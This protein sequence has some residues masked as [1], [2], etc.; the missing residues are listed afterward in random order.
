MSIREQTL[1]EFV[2]AWNAGR[3]PQ[4]REY[5][6]RV[7]EGPERDALADE[8]AVW[9]ST[10]PAPELSS[11]ARDEIRREPLVQQVFSTVG[12]DVA[13]W[14]QTLPRLRSRAG[15]SVRDVAERLV[16]FFGL[17]GERAV[18]RAAGYL[19]EMERGERDAETVS[20]RLLDALGGVLGV[21]GRALSDLGGGSGTFRPAPAG[22]TLFRA[23]EDAGS[24]VEQDIEVLADAAMAPAPG[25][26]DE[27]D[28]LFC[29]GPDG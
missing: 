18:E 14:P 26:M 19:E 5:L 27:L 9:L 4:V 6:A 16:A 2:D 11:A 15:L 24:W 10:A 12:D 13:L 23:D 29:G 25:P 20:R 1:S 22:G 8:I 17:G 28:R 7:P 3:R 21:R